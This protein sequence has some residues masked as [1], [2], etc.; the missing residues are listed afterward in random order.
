MRKLIS[1]LLVFLIVANFLYCFSGVFFYPMQS[2][3]TIGIW[4]L[5]AKAF[6]L[7][8]FFPKTMLFSERYSFSHQQ[9]PLLLPLLFSF[10]Y[11]IVGSINEKA[12]LVVY[13][14]L[15]LSIV[16]L[17]FKTLEKRAGAF[18]ALIFSFGYAVFSPLLGQG[19]RV[20][21]GNADILLTL[22][23]WVGLYLIVSFKNKDKTLYFLALLAAIASQIKT[24]GVFM[25]ALLFFVET[26]FKKKILPFVLGFL[27][28]LAWQSTIIVS[29]IPNDFGF[30]L[31]PFYQLPGSILTVSFF[32]IKEFLNFKNWYIFWPLFGLVV[33]FGP[34]MQRQTKDEVLKPLILISFF[35]FLTYVF[36]SISP[37]T[38]VSSSIDRVLLQISPLFYFV[39][40]D[41]AYKLLK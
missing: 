30:R 10:I 5:K 1:F 36:S 11:K 6:Y 23:Y 12:V 8:G 24:E 35:Y 39:F 22:L 33:F 13:P 32:L 2:M 31:I 29:R 37:E 14:F 27:P 18:C 34:E 19:G 38:Y 28:F 7:E 15:Y 40:F 17:A 3:D 26:G 25:L 41:K 21:A 9:Y 16:F 20:H 4:L